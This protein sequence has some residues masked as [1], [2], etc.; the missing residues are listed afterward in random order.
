MLSAYIDIFDSS[1]SDTKDTQLMYT[2]NKNGPK[3]NPYAWYPRQHWTGIRG[4]TT[5]LQQHHSDMISTTEGHAVPD[6]YLL[7]FAKEEGKTYC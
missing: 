5:H 4:C 1:D 3:T 6:G 2:R 7:F